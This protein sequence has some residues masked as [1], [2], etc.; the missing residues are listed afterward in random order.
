M[1]RNKVGYEMTLAG[2]DGLQHLSCSGSMRACV[3]HIKGRSV[4]HATKHSD[5]RPQ[6]LICLLRSK[7][8]GS[9]SGTLT[10]VMLPNALDC[11]SNLE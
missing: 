10:D 5:C 8:L 9:L 4:M 11:A 7:L 2:V 1:L 6:R 3:H